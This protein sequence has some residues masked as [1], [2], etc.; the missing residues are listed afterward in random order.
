MNWIA[1]LD[2]LTR[3]FKEKFGHLGEKELNWKPNPQTWSIA[4]NIEHLIVVNKTYFPVLTSLKEGSYKAPLI[5][6]V[7][8]VVSFIGKTVLHAVNPDNRKKIKTF[9]VWEPTISQIKGDIL[10]QFENHQHE[11]KRQIESS[12]EFIEKGAIISSPANRN[13]VYK[14]ETAFDIIVTH[15]QRHLKQASEIL[16]KLKQLASDK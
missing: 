10:Q 2:E 8:F 3:T 1:E 6:K 16:D 9:P 4:Q 14:L 11:L 5:A 12:E 13:I 15:E 7:G